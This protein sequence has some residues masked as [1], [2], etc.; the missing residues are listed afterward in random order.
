V[1]SNHDVIRHVTRYGR[2]DTRFNLQYRQFGAPSDRAL[3]TRRARAALLLLLALPG[4]AYLYQGEEL[5]LYEV[6]DI[7]D[8]L[9]HD[10]MFHQTGGE[11]LGRDGCRVPLPWSGDAPPFGFSPAGTTTA[12]WLPQPADW[13]DYTVAR[14]QGDP[15]SMLE[16]YRRALRLRRNEPSLGDGR[17]RWLPAGPDVLTFAR[18]D[19][20]ACVVNLSGADVAL[21]PH[22]EVILASAPVTGGALAPDAAA[23]LRTG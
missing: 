6:E 21:P 17:L 5:G 4:S 8:E 14:Q 13:R 23:W 22:R 19:G 16:L 2:V 9:R 11:N 12:P 15:D 20:F 1:L 3:G 10:P 18:G 7:P